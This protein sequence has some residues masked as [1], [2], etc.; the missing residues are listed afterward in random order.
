MFSRGIESDLCHEMGLKMT[1]LISL[2]TR[3]ISNKI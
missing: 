2:F 1:L 3:L